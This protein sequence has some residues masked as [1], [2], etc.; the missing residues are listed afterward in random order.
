MSKQSLDAFWMPFSANRQFKAAPRMLVSAEGM[1]YQSEDGRTILDATAGLWCVN[2]GH[3]RKE[4]SDAVSRQIQTLD[5]APTFQM[6]HPLAF[7]LAER[8]VAHTPPG[9]DRVFFTNSGSEAVESALKIAIAYHKVNGNPTKTRLIGREKGYHGTNFGGISV[10]GLVNNRRSFGALLSGVDHLK[11]AWVAGSEFSKGMPVRGAEMADEFES[12]LM[13]HGPENVAALIIEPVVG[14][15]GVWIPP[16]GYLQR[17]RQICT[18][19]D[20]VLIFDEVITGFGRV[21]EAFAA[22]R[23]QLIPDIVTSAKGLTN[24]AIPMGAVFINRAIYDA[25]MKGPE[26]TI[27]LFHGYTSSGHP[28]AAAAGLATLDIYERERLFNKA[29]TLEHYWQEALHSL[30]QFEVVKDI[31]NYGLVGAIEFQSTDKMGER[32]Y[33]VFCDCYWKYNIL[34]RCTGDTI[35]MSPPLI[36]EEQHIDQLLDGL[37]LAI[38]Q[39]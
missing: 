9:L 16:Q 7:E 12:I 8:L 29:I 35:A 14:S 32:G 26:D 5:Y 34:V 22:N 36:V 24:G 2:A 37:R 4:I 19:H 20:V 6:G 21:G 11:H 23:M 38:S 15:G 1:Y 13:L 18:K 33:K 3:G 28:V 31:R 10:G 25:F 17:L 30:Q 27:E 39:L